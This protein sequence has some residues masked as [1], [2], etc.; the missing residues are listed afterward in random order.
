MPLLNCGNS[1]KLAFYFILSMIVKTFLPFSK[2][3]REGQP[4]FD[5]FKAPPA[6]TKSHF[7]Q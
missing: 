6:L 2:L 3:K 4:L 5:K 7:P 1:S